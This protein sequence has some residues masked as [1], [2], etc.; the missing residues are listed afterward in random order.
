MPQEYY[1]YDYGTSSKWILA[2]KF[3]D[4]PEREPL[5]L[6]YEADRFIIAL[7]IRVGDI[8]PTPESFFLRVLSQ[9]MPYVANAKVPYAIH[10]FANGKGAAEFRD[11]AKEYEGAITFHGELSP[12]ESFY[13]LTQPHVLIMSASGFS[14]FS[15][16]AGG[17]RRKGGGPPIYTCVGIAENHTYRGHWREWALCPL[18]FIQ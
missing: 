13:H 1:S 17:E 12:F 6:R 8:S 16:L 2:R 15:A 10:V 18:P 11:L 3:Q 4:A 7:H 14:Q 9:L 5:A